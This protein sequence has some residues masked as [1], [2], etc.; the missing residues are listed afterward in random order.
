MIRTGDEY[1]ESLRDGREVWVSGER[2]PDVTVHPQFKPLV[3]ARARIYDMAHED[4]TR[5]V[6][7]Y[8]GADGE[9]C[10]ISTLNGYSAASA[11]MSRT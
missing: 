6:V 9:R 4:A 5:D 8:A 7:S 2:V 1:R 3:D 11:H 10:A